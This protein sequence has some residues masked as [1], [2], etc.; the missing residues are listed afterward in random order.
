M[1][2]PVLKES[3]LSFILSVILLFSILL[4]SLG[5]FLYNLNIDKKKNALD[6]TIQETSKKIE[7]IKS[8]KELVVINILK[9]NSI[10]PSIDV[11][12]LVNEFRE[13]ANRSNVR[14]QGFNVVDDTI[15]TTLISTFW[16]S[17]IH[18]DP[19]ATII[20]MMREYSLWNKYFKLDPIF[21]ISGT[22]I[23]R[24]TWILFR[25]SPEQFQ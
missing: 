12:W 13:A 15:T 20:K 19:A 8:N 17:S 24:T 23:K 18:P 11:R 3:H 5:L 9:S 22:P 14:L 6:I 4:T 21:S 1:Q 7:E 10:R 16:D 25:V 2:S